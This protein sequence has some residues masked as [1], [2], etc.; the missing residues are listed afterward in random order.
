LIDPTLDKIDFSRKINNNAKD[1]NL[2]Q[3]NKMNDEKLEIK[4]FEFK[5]N[6]P[7]ENNKNTKKV[8]QKDN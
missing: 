2:D 5:A 3:E 4:T 7:N 6:F 1:I 8:L